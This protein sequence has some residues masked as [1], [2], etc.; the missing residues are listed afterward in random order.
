MNKNISALI[1]LVIAVGIYF[2]VTSGML[3]DAKTVKTVNDQYAS[4]LADADRLVAARDKV[5]D[6]YNSISEEDRDRVSKMIPSSVDNIRLIIDMNNVAVKHGFSLPDVKALAASGPSK[7]GGSITSRPPVTPNGA[8]TRLSAAS[9]AAP[10]LD[11]V[12][13]TFSATA[14][15]KDF[16]AFLQDLEANLRIMDITRLTITAAEND[17]YAFQVQLQTY[18]LRQ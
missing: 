15:Y 10:V 9:F 2:T 16:I 13:V 3:A 1:L 17:K 11:T 6:Q 4:A 12:A 5:L 8:P 14:S 7:T 18:W